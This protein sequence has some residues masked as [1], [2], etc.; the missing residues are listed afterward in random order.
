MVQEKYLEWLSWI[1]PA[2]LR[3]TAPALEKLFPEPKAVATLG[4][5]KWLLVS[6]TSKKYTRYTD[7]MICTSFI[8]ITSLRHVKK[9]KDTQVREGDKWQWYQTFVEYINALKSMS[10]LYIS[11]T[12]TWQ[13][14][15]FNKQSLIYIKLT[16]TRSIEKATLTCIYP[17]SG[18]CDATGT[19][20]CIT[21]RLHSRQRPSSVLQLCTHRAIEEI[22][23]VLSI[24]TKRCEWK[25]RPGCRRWWWEDQQG[26]S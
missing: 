7:G 10:S 19:R 21:L 20:L 23:S 15:C 1:T 11:Y 5:G 18:K 16:S 4:L 22:R 13:V 9:K 12:Q 8:C 3:R 6:C 25:K 26:G 17:V 14:T 2:S 24:Q